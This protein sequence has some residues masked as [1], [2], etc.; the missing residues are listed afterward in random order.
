MDDKTKLQALSLVN[1]PYKYKM[2]LVSN[3]V[4]IIDAIKFVQQKKEKIT[5]MNSS[6]LSDKET[7]RGT[8]QTE[9]EITTSDNV[10]S[11]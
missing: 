9:E 7:K 4:L 8:M 6:N 10:G 3:G 1:D 11:R 5:R 2:D